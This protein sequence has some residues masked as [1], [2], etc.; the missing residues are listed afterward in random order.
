MNIRTAMSVIFAAIMVCNMSQAVSASEHDKEGHKEH[1]KV[2]DMSKGRAL[3]DNLLTRMF[4]SIELHE[5]EAG[6][7]SLRITTK[8]QGP[9]YKVKGDGFERLAAYDESFSASKNKPLEFKNRNIGVSIKKSA[10]DLNQQKD[11]PLNA[12]S[13]FYYQFKI[14]RDLRSFGGE[15]QVDNFSVLLL[16][17]KLASTWADNA[18]F[19]QQNI[20]QSN[21]GPAVWVWQPTQEP[22]E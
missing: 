22:N 11:H 9:K 14:T 18:F 10:N 4:H 13:P 7:P 21:T 19:K 6:K 3:F 16:S 2:G 15:L 12:L 5:T 17:D 8:E 1:D 20:E